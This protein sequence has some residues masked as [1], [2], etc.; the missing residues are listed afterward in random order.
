MSGE[1]KLQ[2]YVFAEGREH[3]RAREPKRGLRAGRLRR[4]RSLLRR[5]VRHVHAL[6]PVH[7]GS[8][9]RPSAHGRGA[10]E[11][12]GDRHLLRRGPGG[13]G[14]RGQ[15]G[16]HLPRGRAG[17]QGVPAQGPGVGPGPH[18]LRCAPAC[19]QGCNI[20]LHTRDNLVQA[21]Q[22]PGEPGGQRPLDV[23]L[24]ARELRVAQPPG[25]ACRAAGGPGARTGARGIGGTPWAAFADGSRRCGARRCW[26]SLRRCGRTRDLPRW[27]RWPGPPGR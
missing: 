1:C 26:R 9:G 17:L 7:G 19:S 5:P 6:R 23:R 8:G 10:G 18:G 24:R 20:E 15:R 14:L 12:G 16:G 2:D 3:G 21:R 11:P 25:P 4:R 27:T 13:R 22:A